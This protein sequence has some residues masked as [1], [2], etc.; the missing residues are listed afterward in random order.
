MSFF[1][2]F[3]VLVVAA[4]SA[5]FGLDLMTSPLPPEKPKAQVASTAAP[6]S[7]QAKREAAREAA[8]KE[9][10]AALTPVYPRQADNNGVRMV[11]PP[12][13]ETLA[14]VKAET[15]GRGEPETDVAQQPVQNQAEPA[16]QSQ[17]VQAPQSHT[18]PAQQALLAPPQQQSPQQQVTPAQPTPVTQPSAAKC[19]ITACAA[20]YR[21]FNAADCTYQP[22]EGARRI[23]DKPP[24]GQQERSAEIKR[25]RAVDVRT[26]R[27]TRQPD[28]DARLRDVVR[29]VKELTARSRDDEDDFAEIPLRGRRVI[30]IERGRE[31][32]WR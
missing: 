13:S 4:A 12:T 32:F 28:D 27:A 30:V 7:M 19:D 2:Y 16:Q 22:F 26:Q 29:R 10:N 14:N 8:D 20:A 1:V 3:A 25:P 24:A 18:Q 17:P 23:C 15:T 31:D 9:A 21:S 5:L 6:P 11:Y